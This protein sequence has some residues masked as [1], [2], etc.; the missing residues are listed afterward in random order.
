M[1]RLNDLVQRLRAGRIRNLLCCAGCNG[2][3]RAVSN[4]RPGLWLNMLARAD[5]HLQR[6]HQCPG[7][8]CPPDR[9]LSGFRPLF[10]SLFLH[11][12]A[13]TRKTYDFLLGV[14]SI[15]GRSISFPSIYCG[16]KTRLQ[17]PSPSHTGSFRR[18]QSTAPRRLVG[19]RSWGDR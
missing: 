1:H 12:K 16:T 3:Q 5:D 13:H 14:K 7:T 8:A 15:K 9:R 18:Q 2:K 6:P 17:F 19:C 11:T 10:L 4:A